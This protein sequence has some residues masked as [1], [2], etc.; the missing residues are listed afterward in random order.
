[1]NPAFPTDSQP[2]TGRLPWPIAL[3]ALVAIAGMGFT[4]GQVILAPLLGSPLIMSQLS[5]W[6]LP[7]N[8]SIARGVRIAAYMAIVVVVGW[9][10][11]NPRMWFTKS[12]Y[13]NLIGFLICAEIVIRC[14]EVKPTKRIVLLVLST[15]AMGCAGNASD[16]PFIPFLA[17]AFVACVM[18]SLRSL[19][20]RDPSRSRG[21]P[22][23][24]VLI[25]VATLAIG[26]GTTGGFARYQRQLELLTMD[27]FRVA[28]LPPSDIG[29]N[30][31]P[32]LGVVFNPKPSMERIAVIDGRPQERYMRVVAFDTFANNRW[33]PPLRGRAP[34]GISAVRL[35][36]GGAALPPGDS[37]HVR[38]IGDTFNMLL[39][40]LNSASIIG[41]F[42]VGQDQFGSLEV[43][44]ETDEI[45]YDLI[46]P[47]D[48][49]HRGPINLPMREVGDPQSRPQSDPINPQIAELAVKV[50]GEGDA[51]QR[52][53]RIVQ[54]LQSTH[55]YSLEFHPQ[56]KEPLTDFILNN[57]AAH[58]Q[59]FASA[60][61]IMARAAGIP[62]R[63]V[64]GYYMHEF[65]NDQ[66]MVVRDRDAHAWAEC[67][68]DGAG[69]MSFDATPS[70]GVPDERFGPPSRWRTI[71]EAIADFPAVIRQWLAGVSRK[72]IFTI[73]FAA[74]ALVLLSGIFQ[75]RR[76]KKGAADLPYA[77]A[78][79]PQ[80]III[81][82]RFEAWLKRSQ[83]AELNLAHR[84]WREYLAAAGNPQPCVE[85]VNAYDEARF[86]GANGESV[87]RLR[88]MIEEIESTRLAAPVATTAEPR[89]SGQ[90]AQ[91]GE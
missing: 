26:L 47:S 73:I 20:P 19:M 90:A 42:E 85:F 60:V 12:E 62:S 51:R 36:G 83:S 68:I 34:E 75:L 10:T 29:L 50:A 49:N 14:L 79:D 39:A 33:S 66:R 4:A 44:S 91:R 81:A 88:R 15:L 46:V 2:E 84:T 69:W 53:I 76:R 70:G 5:S 27:F 35:A 58:C 21:F 30:D 17:P 1:M 18:F 86:G 8:R 45:A 55:D 87:S 89:R 22:I 64:T 13:T 74:T 25:G 82:S 6:R 59:Y 23:W 3:T 11:T 72:A 65:V 37:L 16:Q 78:S 71:W 32:V 57:R 77:P 24:R 31:A 52:V 54:Y 67:W 28:R 56:G 9:P 80:L 61:A 48:E 40:P 63:M 43:T 38:L 41:D 7:E